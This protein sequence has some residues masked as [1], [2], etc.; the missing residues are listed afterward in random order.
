[1]VA[2]PKS[3]APTT[4]RRESKIRVS[5]NV[6]SLIKQAIT[7]SDIEKLPQT[8]YS[9]LDPYSKKQTVYSGVLVR[10]FVEHYG[11]KGIKQL[12]I[13]AIDDFKAVITRDE[14]TRWDVL[15]AT[16]TDGSHMAIAD[17][18]PARIIFPYDTAKDID[19]LIYNDKWIWQINRI[20][21]Q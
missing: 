21:F 1:M 15:L 14:W 11:N 18:G 6:K 8:Q 5:G 20:A 17:N 3:S 13:R 12:E 10:D 9:V 7:V 16:K 4:T 2:A 19:P